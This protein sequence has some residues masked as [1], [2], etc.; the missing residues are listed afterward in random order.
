MRGDAPTA[1]AE[2]TSMLLWES[3]RRDPDPAAVRTAL[4]EGADA[5]LAVVAAVEHRIGAL[6]WRALGAAGAVEMLSPAGATALG[7][8]TDA[9]LM[10]ELLLLPRA[11]ALAVRPLTEAGLEPL[12][13]KGPAVAARYPQP[14]LRPMED[15]DLL[16]LPTDHRCALD[17]LEGAGW[18]A[19]RVASAEH[20]DTV[21]IHD[22]VPSFSL[23]VHYG[24]ERAP[25]K[26]TALDPAALWARREP[27]DCAG[28]P[29]FGLSLV[30]ELVV[31]AAH[32]G[33][34]FHGFTRLIWIADLA[35]IV[36]DAGARGAP[37]DWDGVCALARQAQCL[38][39]V[40]AA[41]QLAHRVG[42]DAPAELFPLPSH[43]WRGH[44]LRQLLSVT[45]PLR[46]HELHRYRL[47]YAL[48]DA[49]ARRL[50]S[51]LALFGNWHGLRVHL[52]AT[53]DSLRRPVNRSVGADTVSSITR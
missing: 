12:V 35:M 45:W 10:E 11:V 52:R 6:L 14:G 5:A 4:T 17:A 19:A 15:I 46:T 18:Q 8:M 36:G 7:H 33:K 23:E 41:L 38:T 27:L 50:R 53:T 51:L 28:T 42:V 30:D 48:T 22:Q 1:T 9:F 3:C 34:P 24:L 13:F 20:Y 16:L 25:D 21:L 43:G 32:A 39:V 37:V 29:A 47:N 44:A 31:L 49:P 2:A 40:G 26:V